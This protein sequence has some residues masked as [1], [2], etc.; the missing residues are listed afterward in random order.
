MAWCS[1]LGVAMVIVGA[2]GE[3]LMVGAPELYGHGALRQA[4]A[5]APFTHVG[6]AVTRWL[7]DRRLADQVRIASKRL[8]RGDRAAA[9]QQLSRSLADAVTPAEAMIIEMQAAEH[10]WTAWADEVRLAFI[11]KDRP[12]VPDHWLSFGARS[13]PLAEGRTNRHAATPLTA[14]LNYGSRLAEIEATIACRGLGLDPALGLAHAVGL[15]RPSMVLDL[16]EAARSTVEDTVIQLSSQRSFRKGDFAEDSHGVVRM[17]APLTQDYAQAVLPDLRAVLAPVTEHV[18]QA[19]AEVAT[20]D[21][22]VPTALSRS[23]QRG[24]RASRGD[25][26]RNRRRQPSPADRLWTCPECGGSVTDSQRVR[27]DACINA[28]PRHNDEVRGRRSKAIAARRRASNAWESAGGLGTYDPDA[29]PTIQAGL[30]NVKLA[31]IIAATGFSKSFASVVR[32]GKSRP[33]P[34][35]WPAL[36]ALGH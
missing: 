28:D 20:H 11:P 3:P 19:I 32:A 18:A 23:R 33:H 15:N 5:L 9:I 31:E 1:S 16:V 25:A 4:Q 22:Q 29:W 21:L 10:Y 7:L 13:S 2:A 36:S 24:A 26:A 30:V 6:M 17:M 8:Q 14:L 12:R 27:C 34:A 35:S